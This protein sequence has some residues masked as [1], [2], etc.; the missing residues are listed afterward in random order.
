MISQYSHICAGTHDHTQPNLP[1]LRPP[2]TIDD[3]V[4]IAAD[5]FVGPGVTIAQGAV[6]GARSSVFKDLPAW[7]I[8]VGHPARPISDRV[9]ELSHIEPTGQRSTT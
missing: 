7:K 1:L 3:D 9:Y 6:V 5:V 2:I 8:C 4:W